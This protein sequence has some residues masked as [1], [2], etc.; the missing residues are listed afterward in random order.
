MGIKLPGSIGLLVLK[1]W[2]KYESLLLLYNQ[3][4]RGGAL[5]GFQTTTVDWFVG[6]K[7]FV[8][9]LLKRFR[10]WFFKIYDRIGEG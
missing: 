6:F 5:I 1:I 10:V 4:L 2:M 9:G 3:T 7:G 8:Y